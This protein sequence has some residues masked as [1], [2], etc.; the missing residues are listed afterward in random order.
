MELK[1]IQEI[2]GIEVTW[3]KLKGL[4][5]LKKTKEY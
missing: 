1:K 2:K 3:R 5:G 4:N